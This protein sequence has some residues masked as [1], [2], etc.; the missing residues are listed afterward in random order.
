MTPDKLDH[1]Y[2]C[3]MLERNDGEVGFWGF[4]RI[5]VILGGTYRSLTLVGYDFEFKNVKFEKDK[6]Y[7]VII[8]EVE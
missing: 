3:N 2:V 7:R 5:A 1:V 8:E 4:G 6:K